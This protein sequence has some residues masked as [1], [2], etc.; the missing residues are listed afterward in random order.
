LSVSAAEKFAYD[1]ENE[2]DV[3][4]V[5][6]IILMTMAIMSLCQKK[7]LISYVIGAAYVLIR[8]YFLI[9]DVKKWVRNLLFIILGYLVSYILARIHI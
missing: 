8:T 4:M 7:L 6:F 3:F 9:N 2:G 1:I 5:M